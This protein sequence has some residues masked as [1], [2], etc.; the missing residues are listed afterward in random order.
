MFKMIE[1]TSAQSLYKKKGGQPQ[2]TRRIKFLRMKGYFSWLSPT[3][4]FP[5]AIVLSHFSRVWLCATLW[6]AARQAPLS[7]GF[8]A[9]EYW[10]E[11]PCLPPEDLPGLGIKPAS[12]ISPA[13]AGGFLTINTTWKTFHCLG[14]YSISKLCSLRLFRNICIFVYILWLKKKNNKK[15]HLRDLSRCEWIPFYPF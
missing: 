13:L 6:T 12:L 9:Q 14:N 1:Y 15:L 5:G 8:S 3:R 10:S 7:M 4:P 2:S 11:L